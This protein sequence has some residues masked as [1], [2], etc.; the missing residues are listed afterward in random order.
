M[1]EPTREELRAQLAAMQAQMAALQRQISAQQSGSG[2]VAQDG[3]TA[4]GAG[5]VAV[6]GSV[7]GNIYSGEPP[8]DDRQALAIY[9]RMFVGSA[10][11]LPLRGVDIRASDPRGDGQPMALEQVYVALDTTSQ[12]PM[13]PAE[14]KAAQKEQPNRGDDKMVTLSALEALIANRRMALLGDP[15]SGK[16]TFLTHLGLCLALHGLEPDAGWRDRLS[17][18][19][20]EE[21]ALLPIS[22]TLRDFARWA[23]PDAPPT[24]S[25][26]WGFVTTR[27]AEQNLDFA[28]NPL[29][30]AL[31]AGRAILLLDGLDEIPSQ[32]SRSHI[33]DT[34]AAFLKRYPGCRAVVTCR[35][36]SYQDPAWQ[37]IGL[38]SL[39]LAPFDQAKIH[40]FIDAWYAG[41]LQ[42]GEVTPQEA[43]TQ[44]QALRQA[45]HRPD[46]WR[47]APNPLLLTVMALVHAHKGRLPDARATL[48]EESV[49]MLLWR[50]D[51]KKQSETPPL[52]RLLT[53]ADRGDVD[54]KRTLGRLAFE[55]HATGRAHAEAPDNDASPMDPPDAEALADI[56][57]LALQKA[58]ALLHPTRSLDW[59]NEL[60]LTMKL[61]AGLLL[62]RAPSLFTFPHRTF[63]EYLAGSH[64]AAQGDFA[65]QS[66]ELA[67][68]TELWRQVILLAVGKLVYLGGDTAK[69]LALVS[70]LC[71]RRHP[72]QA[73]DWRR[74]WLAGEAL[75][76]MGL[77]R[78][79]E[80]ELGQ[81][82]LERVQQRLVALIQTPNA[83]TPP[84]RLAA[85]RTLDRLGDPRPGVGLRPDGLPDLAWVQIPA[86]DE[87]G[88]EEF[89]YGE[90]GERRK[91][92]TFW[93]AKYPV[94]YR[95]FQAFVDAP[96]GF[97]NPN[98]WR[99]LARTDNDD[100]GEQAFKFWDHPRDRVSWYQAVAFCRWLNAKAEADPSLLPAGLPGGRWRIS[101]PTEWQWEKAARSH[102]GRAY[103]WGE[104]Y[105]SGYANV[106][107]TE[108]KDGPHYLQSSSAVG[109]YPQGAT[110]DGI[111]DLSGNVWE[112]CLNEY[113][114][115]DR[116]QPE[117]DAVRVLRGGSWLYSA[118]SALSSSR[119]GDHPYL[120][121][122]LGGIRCVVVPISH[123]PLLPSVF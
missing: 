72:A 83:L 42:L 80:E 108:G 52:R 71:P 31:E 61:R 81:E 59:A 79:Q 123:G 101:L 9:R 119:Y 35:T 63:Q 114:K 51:T 73:L 16:S 6:G 30:G 37:L 118:A 11:Y 91:E 8:T 4:A 107:E 86:A 54:L 97:A 48:Y 23:K 47:L 77:N 76:E 39:E 56:G 53:Q 46:L 29:H 28:A 75:L 100:L 32:A 5:G 13:T 74:I 40:N 21:G 41:L 64:L 103:P 117:G 87:K 85:A 44:T 88:R 90:K 94:T 24:P 55:A 45:V 89:L 104:R 49:D 82:L 57:E 120:R 121:S 18:W 93:M 1:S 14:R 110:P 96:D 111:L 95:Q 70:E 19:P 62:E 58:L 33:R 116:T 102:D 34:L 113:N 67:A 20:P 99:G 84:E 109:L 2:A 27:L 12:R 15:G 65:R 66:W 25:L 26:L 115:P 98:W 68:Q 17:G 50:W 69:P 122:N 43:R 112:W 7:Y 106:D 3:G 92:A 10:R 22:V 38:P 36:L 78:V 105:I 60:I